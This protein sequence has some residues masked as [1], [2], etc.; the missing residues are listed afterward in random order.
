MDTGI[1]VIF[2]TDMPWESCLKLKFLPF[3][4]YMLLS[5]IY[6]LLVIH[7]CMYIYMYFLNKI[8]ILKLA[9]ILI[10]FARHLSIFL[11]C[12]LSLCQK[13]HGSYLQRP[14]GTRLNRH[15]F[16]PNRHYFCPFSKTGNSDSDAPPSGATTRKCRA[17]YGFGQKEKWCKPCRSKKRCIH[18]EYLPRYALFFLSDE[19]MRV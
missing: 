10:V 13:P 12:V 17:L 11:G 9:R 4:F 3:C 16:C 1:S 5:I 18:F 8:C 6:S 2:L 19:L 15:Y 14:L 7:I